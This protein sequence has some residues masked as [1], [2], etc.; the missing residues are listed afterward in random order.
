MN[1]GMTTT[2]RSTHIAALCAL[3]IALIPGCSSLV[4]AAQA[5]DVTYRHLTTAGPLSIH[6]VTFDLARKDLAVLATVGAGVKGSETVPAMVANLPPALGTPVA[7]VNGDYFEFLTEPR[8]RGTL[9]GTCVVDGEL[10]TAPAAETFWIDARRRPHLGAVRS[11][12]TLTWPDGSGEPFGLNCSTS[13][14][15]SEVRAADVVL[16]T[17]AFGPST[18]TEGGREYVLGPVDPKAWLPLRVNAVVQARVREIRTAGNTPLR[19]G[20]M[21]VSVAR[22]ADKR[23]PALAVGNTLTIATAVTPSLAGARTAISGAPLVLSGGQVRDGLDNTVRAPRTAVGFAGRRCMFVVVDG[24]QPGLS[25][26][27]SHRELGK[28]MQR[29]GCTDAVN[30]DGGGSSTFWF[31][32]KV[33]NS[34]SDRRLRPVGNALLLVRKGRR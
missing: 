2:R 10:V 30:L 4:R 24:R 25:V 13:D 1:I 22:K 14:Y 29:L 12:F 8:Y 19:P 3:M 34:P 20:T 9:Q 27:M 26:G 11:K 31:K 18:F 5:P 21:V 33:L 17:P 23:V 28:L 16:Y 6:V 32:G 15:K 7:A